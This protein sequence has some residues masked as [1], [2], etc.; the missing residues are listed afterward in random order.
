MNCDGSN[1]AIGVFRKGG[2]TDTYGVVHGPGEPGHTYHEFLGDEYQSDIGK[3]DWI[4]SRGCFWSV[5]AEII[6]T[7]RNGRYPSDH[8]FVSATV[9]LAAP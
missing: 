8:F 9:T 4:F 2:W 1:E 6:R 7:A 5:G 3:M